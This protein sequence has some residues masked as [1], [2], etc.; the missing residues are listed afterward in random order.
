VLKDKFEDEGEV[1]DGGGGSGRS[2]NDGGVKVVLKS[3]VVA[4]MLITIPT[5]PYLIY[6]LKVLLLTL[7]R[8]NVARRGH[9]DG[10]TD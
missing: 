5:P 8:S 3:V 1:K 6:H 2:R 4:R 10:Q 9:R 7:E